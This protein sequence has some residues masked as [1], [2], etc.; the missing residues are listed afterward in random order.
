MSGTD[1]RE[2][3]IVSSAALVEESGQYP[4]S[5]EELGLTRRIGRVAGL[6]KI[7]INLVRLPP[8]RRSSW[9][10][11][12]E[13]EEEFVYV[14]DGEVDAW[15]DGVLHPMKQGDLAAFPAGTGICHTFIN[16]SERDAN[17]MVGG[18]TDQSNNRIFYPQHPQRRGDIPWSHWWDTVTKR[19]Q[20]PHDGLPDV[21]REAQK[22]RKSTNDPSSRDR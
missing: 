15:I 9:P 4:N 16:N 21:L 13:K 8:G 11:A 17:L 12:E 3:F 7:G 20:G 14:L 6:R 2:P 18:Q 22:R 5:D 1:K 19:T 10:H